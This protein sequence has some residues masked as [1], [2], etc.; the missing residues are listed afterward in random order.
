MCGRYSQSQTPEKLI[1][2]FGVKG[3][4]PADLKPRYNIAPSQSAP[5][6]VLLE[7]NRLELFRWGLIP[8]WTKDPSIGN[9]MI[10]ARAETLATKASYRRP[11]KK[12]RCLVPA[13][14]FYEW[15]TDPGEKTKTPMRV[16]LRSDDPFAFAGLW[17][18]W[19]DPDGGEIRSFTIITTDANDALRTIHERMPVILKPEDEAKWLDPSTGPEKL[20]KMLYEITKLVNSPR[21]DTPDC[22][23]PADSSR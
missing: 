1:Q 22:F 23:N 8:Y 4:P 11:F 7:E 9:R 16:R 19:K 2:R 3:T 5:V 10:N 13:D 14:G 15:R 6:V 20:V 18:L 21:N 12:S 17:D